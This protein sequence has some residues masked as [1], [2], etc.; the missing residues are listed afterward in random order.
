ML[1]SVSMDAGLDAAAREATL[2]TVEA[3][4]RDLGAEL[5]ATAVDGGASYRVGGLQQLVD[6][7]NYRVEQDLRVGEA[8][9]LPLSLLVMVVVFGGLLA[10]GLPILGAVASIA[11]G[12]ACLLAF[13]YAIELDASVPS[14]VSVLGLGLCIDYGL[15][16][17]SRYREEL[18]RLQ[19]RAA[20]TTDTDGPTIC[21]SPR[22]SAPS[23][24]PAARCCSAG[25]PWRSACAG[26]CSSGPASCGRSGPPG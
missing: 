8:V 19:A 17:V 6:E 11:G 5:A 24:P 18:R 12:L 23:A 3:G 2:D 26:C 9:A 21:S 16:L 1:V 13:S 7:I 15:L 25:S 10:A 4:L 14:V 20:D 22:W